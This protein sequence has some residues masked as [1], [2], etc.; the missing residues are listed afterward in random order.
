MKSLLIS[1]TLGLDELDVTEEQ[2]PLINEW[3]AKNYITHKDTTYKL[4]S[5]YRAGTLGLIQKG[6][7]YLHVIGELTRDLFIGDGDLLEGSASICPNQRDVFIKVLKG[8][9]RLK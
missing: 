3:L 2:R 4:N 7:A 6:T 5:K 9:S 8:G 1:L